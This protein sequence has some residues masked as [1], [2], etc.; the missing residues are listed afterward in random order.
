MKKQSFTIFLV[1]LI[2][3]IST[4]ALAYDIAVKNADGVTIYYNYIN[5]GKELEVTYKSLEN[6]YSEYVAIPE[7]VTYESITRKVTSIGDYAFYRC[8]SL[9]LVTIPNSVT[10]IG[11]SAFYDSFIQAITI[12]NSVTSIG[13]N[14]F[15][16][17]NGL[18]SITIPNSV[19]SIGAWAFNECTGLKSVTIGNSVT[20]I[21]EGAFDSCIRL[22][23]VTI[24]NG[25]IGKGA[26][27]WCEGLTSV[28]IGNGV[29]SIGSKAFRGCSGLTSVTIGN[30]VKSIGEEAFKGCDLLN[31]VSLIENP[32]SINENTFTNNTYDNATL[33]VP[34]GTIDKYK[35]TASW[36]KFVF[37]E[38]GTGGGGGET[39]IEKCEK[40]TI[41]Y[42]NGKLTFT[43]STEGATCQYNITDTDIK[44]GS[45]NEIQ[46][47]VTYEIS[48]YATKEGYENSETATATLCWIDVEPKM[49][50]IT[51]DIANVPAHALLI[52][53]NGGT[54][55]VQGADDGTPI[56]V[57]TFDG[58]QVGRAVSRNGAA[59][60][61]TN[62]H[63]G[64][65]AI[66]KIGNKSV[67]FVVK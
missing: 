52:Q 4:R 66:V 51:N 11:N 31:V 57:Y 39:T 8:R 54:I 37:I 10:S 62:I 32:F 33:Y 40:P 6:S 13:I 15:W 25:D 27:K 58:K 20:S 55:N 67:K 7:E 23:S 50:G 1:L 5:D 24:P 59:F 47:S 56:S 28:T 17:C 3:M 26:F 12:P 29:K 48:V 45:G 34:V 16:S 65:T 35:A 43:C 19:T 30:G 61:D 42:S 38:E 21:G 49:E 36:K 60:I 14:A 2:C 46:L 9:Y 44:A 22:T 63:P 53:S 41:S 18:A 64:N